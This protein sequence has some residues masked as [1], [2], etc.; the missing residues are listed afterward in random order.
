[1]KTDSKTASSVA[2]GQFGAPPGPLGGRSAGHR[3]A[4][5]RAHCGDTH[6]P[7]GHG[8]SQQAS[9]S[10]SFLLGKFF[11]SLLTTHFLYVTV[12]LA[13]LLLEDY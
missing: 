13:F 9:S 3:T 12:S 11:C 4:G 6:P 5:R 1:M 7:P 2:D 8:P 10:F